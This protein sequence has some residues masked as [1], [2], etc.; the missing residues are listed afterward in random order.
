[1][2]SKSAS[3]TFVLS[4]ILVAACWMK[5]SKPSTTTATPS[6]AQQPVLIGSSMAI[7]QQHHTSLA[8]GDTKKA[9]IDAALTDADR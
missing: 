9:Q 5:M 4:I 2:T 8:Q 6:S 3:M 7:Q 1:M